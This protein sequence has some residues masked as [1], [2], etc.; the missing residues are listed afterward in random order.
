ME[1]VK[2]QQPVADLITDAQHQPGAH[3]MSDVPTA[4]STAPV[5]TPTLLAETWRISPLLLENLVWML[6]YDVEKLVQQPQ[7]VAVTARHVTCS[8][9]AA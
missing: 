1:P 4:G 9:L 8:H 3:R 7:A 2:A 6:G 5:S